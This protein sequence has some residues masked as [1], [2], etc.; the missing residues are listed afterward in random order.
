MYQTGTY[1]Q[2]DRLVKTHMDFAE[3]VVQ[4]MRSQLPVFI[5]IDE[6]KSAAIYGLMEAAGRFDPGRGVLFKTYAE[7]RIRG[8]IMDEVRKMDWF[9]RSM[10]EK[11]GRMNR[12]IRRLEQQ[13]GRDPTEE[14]IAEAMNLSREQYQTVL[15]EIGQ[16]GIVSLNEILNEESDGATFLD[17]VRDDENKNP[18][19]QF[20]IQELIRELAVEINKLSEKE[21]LVL[22]LFYYEELTQKEISEILELSEGRISQLHSQALSKL[23]A[24][25]PN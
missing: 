4:R 19:E 25:M 12:E 13:L 1:D 17:Q 15:K 5:S 7:T 10:R 2:R 11:H 9:S 20:G 8:A 6:L 21:R 24:G 14:E 18:D 22:T 3:Y 23:K 16:L